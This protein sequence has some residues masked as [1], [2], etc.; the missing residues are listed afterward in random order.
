MIPE[1]IY[2]YLFIYLFLCPYMFP[3]IGV[4]LELQLLAYATATAILS[5]LLLRPNAEAHGNTGSLIH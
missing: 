5:E 4:N 1:W 2:F 3:R